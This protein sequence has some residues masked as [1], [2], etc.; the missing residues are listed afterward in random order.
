M[1]TR[2]IDRSNAARGLT[3]SFR[4]LLIPAVVAACAAA[5]S[6]HAQDQTDPWTGVYVGANLGGAWGTSCAT[7]EATAP[8]GAAT[9]TGSHCPGGGMFTGGV[10]AGY[11]Y[12]MHNI[13][14]GLEGDLDGATSTSHS[15][16]LT[17]AG[18][19][20]V[21]AGTYVGASSKTPG[22]IGTIRVRLGY[23][24][25]PALI[26][27]TGGGAF[28]GGS[29]GGSIAYIPPLGVAP[30][31]TFSGGTT[32]TRSGW[33]VGGGVEYKLSSNWS[34]KAEDLFINFA[35]LTPPGNCVGA[36]SAFSNVTFRSATNAGNTNLFRVGVNYKF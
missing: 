27:A 5:A 33:T 16:T 2:P 17:T 7:Y 1:T 22:L 25:G 28:A 32:G 4:R 24:F 35:N 9:F 6:A 11:N 3:P 15:Y 21:P 19:P 36:C 29:G 26:Y 20:G 18:A 12:N 31:A 14:L 8:G 10:Q 23:A 34:I 13:V 30:T